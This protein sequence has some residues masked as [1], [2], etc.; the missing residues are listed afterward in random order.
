MPPAAPHHH[1]SAVSLN[2]SSA[3]TLLLSLLGMPA[4]AHEQPE[5]SPAADAPTPLELEQQE[6]KA[7]LLET[8][9]RQLDTTRL[10]KTQ[11][12]DLQDIFKTE[13]S[14]QVGS[15]ARN[16]Q[17]IMLRGVE[18]LNLNIQIDGARQGANLFHHQGRIQVDPY[19]LKEVEI[20][21]GPA[22]ADGGPGALGGSVRFE[23]VDAQDLLLPGRRF[24][25][26]LGGQLEHKTE[27]RG[28]VLSAY[29]LL[30]ENIGLLAYARNLDSG[31][32]RDGEGERIRFTDG[33]RDSYLLKLSA[34]DQQGHSLWLSAERNSNTGGILRANVPWQTGNAVQNNDH[35]KSYRDTFTLRHRYQPAGQSLL[36]LQTTLYRNDSRLHLYRPAADE[37]YET[38]SQGADIR[39]TWRFASAGIDHALTAGVDHFHD[40]GYRWDGNAHYDERALNYGV[41]VQ[42][43]LD[44][45]AVRL[46]LGL[47]GDFYDTRYAAAGFGTSGEAWSPNAS[48]EWNPLAGRDLT[49]FAGYG[50]S[51]RGG[52]LNQAGWL[53]KYTANFQLG[54]RGHLDPERAQQRQVGIRWHTQSLL[55]AGDHAGLEWRAYNT[56]IRDYQVIPGEG[57]NGRTD[58]I[59]NPPGSIV[60]RGYELSGHWGI[61][62]L[63][64]NAV[65]SHNVIRNWDGQPLD[66]RGDSARVGVS[67][68]D[69]LVLDSEWAFAPQWSAGYTLTAVQRLSD[70]P[71]GNPDKP[72]YGVHDLRLSWMSRSEQDGLV[73]TVGIDNLLDKR[74]ADHTTVRTLQRTNTAT[75]VA[76]EQ[77][78]ILEPG[79]NLKMSADWFF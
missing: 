47:R 53:Q 15:G 30:A 75:A 70:V 68:G 48:L 40:R 9:R 27:T 71:V 35:Q 16:G 64:L 19:L 31:T 11:A 17:K 76:G 50:E 72:G 59:F 73:L 2:T 45:G 42:D 28:G 6:I 22:P 55:S 18:D 36:D 32:A 77:Y 62:N 44:V 24:G 21:S 34:L 56:H 26:R 10:Q 1:P 33:Q 61:D 25:A 78:A 79:R 66:T 12:S 23:T 14:I 65:Y 46:S 54:E 3:L 5:T 38:R 13:P 29:G 57:A 41:F 39:N 74:Y 58:R 43:R 63:L 67:T 52:K 51:V 8:Q 69:R 4:L 60:S 49:L 7:P 20:D 37:Q